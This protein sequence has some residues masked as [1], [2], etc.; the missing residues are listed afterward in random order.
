MESDSIRYLSNGS[1]ALR[2]SLSLMSRRV[3]RKSGQAGE[4]T[5]SVG[6]QAL[7]PTGVEETGLPSDLCEVG[8][9]ET[10]TT[11]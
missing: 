10:I 6:E 9:S 5:N 1:I 8:P 4:V 11:V 7:E 2:Q 3:S